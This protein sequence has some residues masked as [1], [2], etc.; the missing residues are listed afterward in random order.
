MTSTSTSTPRTD[1]QNLFRLD[2]RKTVVVGGGSGLGQASSI[3]L[4]Q[5]GADV[6]VADINLEGVDQTVA[7]I[8][9]LG[10]KAEP[11]QLD[12][13]DADQVT[14]AAAAHPDTEILVA[15]PGI[16][17]R[18]RVLD[19]TDDEFE[20]V[21]DVSLKGTYRLAR[22]FAPG[23]V[24]AG[25]GSIVNFSS[26]RAVVVEPGQGLYA[27]AKAGVLQLTK[28]LAAELGPA[29]VRVNAVAP[30]PFQ[31][32]LTAQITKDEDWHNAY[33]QKTA[34]QRWATADE[35]VGAILFLASDASTFVT[36]TLQLVE[37]GWTA[38]DGRF[39]PRV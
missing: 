26:F 34:L 27:A 1:Y 37:G 12:V 14:A 28:V 16:N 33:A 25:R 17:V 19:T 3:A 10:L 36:G 7:T 20:R 18:K 30:G 8:E 15:T 32:P 13:T 9:G 38:V 6:V 5:Y 11:R 22:A 31:T 23:M 21:L 24:A 4:A 2:G 39:V 29:G 35:I